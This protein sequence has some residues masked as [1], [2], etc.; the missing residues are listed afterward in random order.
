[1]GLMQR[2]QGVC[3]SR[4][5]SGALLSMSER[6]H[7][8]VSSTGCWLQSWVRYARLSL[9]F[10][11]YNT[12]SCFRSLS[13]GKPRSFAGPHIGQPRHDNLGRKC[14]SGA[15]HGAQPTALFQAE[16]RG[17]EGVGTRSWVRPGG[18][19]LRSTRRP[20]HVHGFG[21]NH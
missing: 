6:I 1:M 10:L 2:S 4:D 14:D 5:V 13:P 19:V 9:S 8:C 20:C 12:S 18:D 15:L 3:S 21:E 17:Q 7:L 11:Q 16:A